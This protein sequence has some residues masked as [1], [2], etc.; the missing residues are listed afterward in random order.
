LRYITQPVKKNTEIISYSMDITQKVEEIRTV[1]YSRDITQIVEKIETVT[2]SGDIAQIVEEIETV[3]YSRD[4]TRVVEEIRT[5]TYSRDITR[6]V[7][8]IDF[9]KVISTGDEMIPDRS[10]ASINVRA[11][12]TFWPDTYIYKE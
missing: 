2:Y 3:T 11:I 4:I 12:S 1:K 7:E 9:P 6:V 5:V 10:T 8:E